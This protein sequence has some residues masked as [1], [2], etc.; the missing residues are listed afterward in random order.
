M[1]IFVDDREFSPFLLDD[2]ANNLQIID[3]Y[4]SYQ[5][6]ISSC[7]VSLKNAD[8]F[9]KWILKTGICYMGGAC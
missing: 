8:A 2:L 9:I 7:A 3:I 5:K 6:R 4:F 1:S